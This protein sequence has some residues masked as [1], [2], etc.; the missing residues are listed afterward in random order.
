MIY[1]LTIFLLLIVC[2]GWG[3]DKLLDVCDVCLKRT[4]RVQKYI[5]C[6]EC[7]SI[8]QKRGEVNLHPS[9]YCGVF[10][11]H[12]WDENNK[13]ITFSGQKIKCPLKDNPSKIIKK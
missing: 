6:E 12:S 5:L 13:A 4:Y 7:W 9:R 11:A 2:N 8:Y 10:C 3:E 1:L